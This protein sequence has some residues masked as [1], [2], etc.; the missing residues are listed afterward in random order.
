MGS[1]ALKH[2]FIFHREGRRYS[3]LRFLGKGGAACVWLL[4]CEGEYFAGKQFVKRRNTADQEVQMVR[5]AQGVGI[6]Q[7]VE[8]VETKEETWVIYK[9]GGKPLGSLM[10]S[11]QGVFENG[12][13]LYEVGYSDAYHLIK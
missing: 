1:P 6:V 9:M 11:V 10:F 2:H 8:V 13:R 7:L 12:E 5:Q 4:E 3:I